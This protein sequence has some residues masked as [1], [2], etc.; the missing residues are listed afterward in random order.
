MHHDITDA[1]RGAASS[2]NFG[3]YP[4]DR[5]TLMDG[6]DEIERLRRELDRST[7][8]ATEARNIVKRRNAG[9]T[10][11]TA[12]QQF[13]EEVATFIDAPAGEALI[14]TDPAMVCR[15]LIDRARD[16]RR[17]QCPSESNTVKSEERLPGHPA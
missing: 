14:D 9:V 2:R 10:K 8:H 3:G 16:L 12:A 11:R 1:L 4:A 7:A 5:K 15:M 6:A 17:I 13:L